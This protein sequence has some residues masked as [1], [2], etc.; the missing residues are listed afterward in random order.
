[1]KMSINYKKI[2]MRMLKKSL[3]TLLMAVFLQ[4]GI[5][6]EG[7]WLPLLLQALNESE[8]QALGMKMT[9]EDVYSVN[10]GS[11]KDA[12]VHFG[13][14]CTGEVISDQGLV[15]TNHHCGYGQIQSHSSLEK[16]YLEDGFWA[17][18]KG[19]ELPNPGL[20]VTFIDRIED[21]SKTALQGVNEDM[22]EKERQSTID[23]NLDAIKKSFVIRPFFKG[24]QYFLFVTLTYNDVRLVG[25]PPSSIGKFGADTDNWVWPRHTGDFSMFRIYA[26]KDNLPAEYS[27][28]NVP[29]KPKHSLPVSLDG[30]YEG[31]FTLVFGFPGST[32]SYLPSPA[33]A[34]EVDVLDPAKISIRDKTLAIYNREMRADPEVKIQYASKQSSLSNAWK[35]WQGIILGINRTK[36][37]EK[38]QKFEK[39]FLNKVA[40]NPE[41]SDK[42]GN[43]LGEFEELY[44]KI[45]PY[46]L[47]RDYYNEITGRNV[48]LLRITRNYLRLASRYEES[49][50]A[51]Y[52]EFKVRLKPYMQ[53]FYKDY[54]PNIDQEVFA[55]L[56]KKYVDD[57]ELTYVPDVLTNLVAKSGGDFEKMAA[58][59][60]EKSFLTNEKAAMDMFD[61]PAKEAMDMLMQDPAFQLMKNWKRVYDDKVAAKYNESNERINQLQR[62]YMA[63][64]MEVFPNK[65][66][67]PDANSTM[68]VSYGNVEP[69]KPRDGV[70][71]NIK[72][73]L[74][75]IMEKYVPGDY[76]FDV[77]E[78]LR[79]LYR[80]QDYGQYGEGSKMPVCFI[81]SNHTTGGNSGSPAIDAHGN[82]VGLN[83]DRAWEGTMSDI[84][85]DR[86][87]CRNIMVDARYIL[88]IVDK[89]AGAKHLVDEMKLV[90]PKALKS[91]PKKRITDPRMKVAPREN[92]RHQKRKN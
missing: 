89:Y 26:G 74:G 4:I 72:T 68:R 65:T 41:W 90:H 42:Y 7:M 55:V 32:D 87:I 88:F 50:A 80:G 76:E 9:A 66:F 63:A 43:V 86:S 53:K 83:F 71:Y 45:E 48:E 14:F 38:K 6:G 75:G 91:D 22:S 40:R 2:V 28:E 10:K 82:L 77:P 85:Y 73:Y 17:M 78:K 24:N 34:M 23:K 70:E 81:G 20:F 92:M 3:L 58:S 46:S 52:D 59:M 27:T 19:E 16:N 44:A 54:R 47:A 64:L 8:M 39:K 56:S 1:M 57:M 5:A 60:Y 37:L 13:G 25:A 36:G 49:G 67:Y 69:Y 62:T 31:D 18:N 30:V 21:V 51:G 11:L 61:K 35:K 33:M 12:I 15:L 79:R 29:M 84:S